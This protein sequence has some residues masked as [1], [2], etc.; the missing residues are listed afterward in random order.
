[1]NPQNI[2]L[3]GKFQIQKTTYILCIIILCEVLQEKKTKAIEYLLMVFLVTGQ[4]KNFTA[5]VCD[6]TYKLIQILISSLR[7]W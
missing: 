3:S 4:W 6:R 2:M 1:M 7:R 5:K